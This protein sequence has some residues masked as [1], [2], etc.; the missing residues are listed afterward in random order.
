M[1]LA[2]VFNITINKQGETRNLLPALQNTPLGDKGDIMS[3]RERCKNVKL[4]DKEKISRACSCCKSYFYPGSSR[5]TH[6]QQSKLQ[7]RSDIESCAVQR[8]AG[9]IAAAFCL[10]W[11]YTAKYCTAFNRWLGNYFKPSRCLPQQKSYLLNYL[12]SSS[13][14]ASCRAPT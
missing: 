10:A 1:E 6:S 7:Q 13:P 5:S 8:R 2:I 11:N 14:I 9:D 4:A 12:I 3:G